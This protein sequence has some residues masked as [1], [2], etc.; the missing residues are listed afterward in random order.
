M[1]KESGGSKIALQFGGQGFGSPSLQSPLPLPYLEADLP[2]SD[3]IKTRSHFDLKRPVRASM[4]KRH[5][6]SLE[7]LAKIV[8]CSGVLAVLNASLKTLPSQVRS[9]PSVPYEFA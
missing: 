6:F 9:V 5:G 8:I 7:A 4:G 3:T 2:R 1:N